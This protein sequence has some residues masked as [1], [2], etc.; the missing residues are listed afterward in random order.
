[1][2]PQAPN[3]S[4]QVVDAEGQPVALARGNGNS[5]RFPNRA[6][7]NSSM[8]P[9]ASSLNCAQSTPISCPA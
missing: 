6:W 1:M 5:S 9:S 7:S 3:L 8:R 4:I 2:L